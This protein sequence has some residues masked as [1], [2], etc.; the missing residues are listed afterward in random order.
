MYCN[1]GY[2]C[3]ELL[4]TSFVLHFCKIEAREA[5]AQILR[6]SR[7]SA[8]EISLGLLQAK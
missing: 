2:V 6:L 1:Y 7:L 5:I 8:F 4:T 3:S